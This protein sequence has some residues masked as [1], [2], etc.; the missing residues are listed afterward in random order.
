[1]F[2]YTKY[3]LFCLSIIAATSL[4]AQYSYTRFSLDLNG[5]ISL[6]K[7]SIS[8][9]YGGIGELGLRF[10]T[11]RYLS[12]RLAI[13]YGILNGSQ[14]VERPYGRHD[15]VQSFT[16]YDA[17]FYY[18]SG[19]GLLNLERVFNLRNVSK[20][21]HRLN[22]F[23]VIGAG[24]MYPSIHAETVY[25][26]KKHYEKNVRFIHN[27]FGLDFKH[28]LSPAFD[29]NFGAEYRLVQTYYLDGAFTDNTF[30]G[31]YSGYVG[32]SYNIGG[33]SN[34]RHMEW[35]NLDNIEQVTYVPYKEEDKAKTEQPVTK[36]EEP[37][38]D[39]IAQIEKTDTVLAQDIITKIDSNFAVVD[40][41]KD[42]TTFKKVGRHSDIKI[43][44]THPAQKETTPT[45]TE[46]KVAV[47]DNATTLT[48]ET[49]N[50]VSGVI[51]PP[52]KYNVIVGTYA[53]PKYAFLFRD[54]LRKEGFQCAI[55]K[56]GSHSRMYR[57]AVY[58]GDDR[59]EANRE[60]RRYMA[61]FNKQAWLHIYNK[62]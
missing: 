19:S 9:N 24:Y 1:M 49:L 25:G 14:N 57:V 12:G 58:F 44:D 61:K 26:Q 38:I 10:A 6:P 53:G 39:T 32:I 5:G 37:A 31:F 43:A 7:T 11:S 28:Y 34:R 52:G 33:N 16:K 18:F 29:L 54:K 41:H 50:S 15:A 46:P 27:N 23:L 48:N 3:L 47:K 51:V 20:K 30:D 22:T 45:V 4:F 55:F 60:L 8:G 17:S 21:F 2:K 40:I 13:G 56:D 36:A 42:T 35:T 59:K 62:K